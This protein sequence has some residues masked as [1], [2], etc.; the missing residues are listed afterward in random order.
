MP[1]ERKF[2]NAGSGSVQRVDLEDGDVLLPIYFKEIGKTQ[3]ATTVLRC[4]F[5]GGTLRYREHGSE[6]TVPVKRGLYEPSITEFNGRYYLTM[7]NALGLER[8]VD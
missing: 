3:Y 5:D 2:L 7:R 1:N 4:E 6:L 8:T